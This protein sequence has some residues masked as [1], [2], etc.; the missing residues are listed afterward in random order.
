MNNSALQEYAAAVWPEA[1]RIV[2]DLCRI[3]APSHHEEKR[4][5]YCRKW[6][7]DQGFKNVCIDPALNVI[8]PVNVT[9]NNDLLVVMAHTDTVFPDTEPMPV[10]EDENF[11]YAPGVTDDTANLAVLMVCSRYYKEHL[12]ENSP[13]VLF[14]ANSCE[15]GL[16]NLKGCRQ[17]F[18]DY[19][20]R[21]REF[22]S[23]DSAV[24]NRLVTNAVGS[25]RYQVTVRTEGGHSFSQFG[26]RNA[27]AVLATLINFLYTVKVP[28]NGNSQTTY[29]VGG[30]SGGTSVNTIAQSA[31]MLYEYRSTDRS[32]LK[33]MQQIFNNAITALRSTGAAVEVQLLGER[34]CSGEIDPERFEKLKKR[35]YQAAGKVLDL[36]LTERS[37]ST[38]CNIP[39]SLGVPAI[40]F[41]TCRGSGVHTRE[42][43]L[44][45]ASLQ[46][47]CHLLLEFLYQQ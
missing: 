2:R 38:D 17:I 19:G 39:L 25:H 10:T 6:F 16:G 11:I 40:C 31:E 5:E 12:P 23:L 34:P 36:P 44:E 1:A 15:E 24:M 9:S 3:P 27:I 41:G 35:Y 7:E 32:C 28:V 42:E 45:T 33:K 46:D 18:A 14:V 37:A 20:E 26:N 13:G 30:I 4:A 22:V 43:K 8:A 21:I 47:G 29:N